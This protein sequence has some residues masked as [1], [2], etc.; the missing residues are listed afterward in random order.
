[1]LDNIIFSSA[2]VFIG[3]GAFLLATN[4]C[5]SICIYFEK[6]KI[7]ENL[8][9]MEEENEARIREKYCCE[10]CEMR[11]KQPSKEEE[12]K[13]DKP[14]VD[15]IIELITISNKILEYQQ[16]SIKALEYIVAFINRSQQPPQ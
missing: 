12:V 9:L 7:Q 16:S 13:T 4:L 11:K 2:G 15:P 10:E 14:D 3:L 8:K 6:R 1:M 5:E